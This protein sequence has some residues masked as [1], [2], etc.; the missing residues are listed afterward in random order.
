M[1][2]KSRWRFAEALPPHG[3]YA[4]NQIIKDKFYFLIALITPVDGLQMNPFIAMH[5]TARLPK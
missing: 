1:Q 5:I 3:S 4:I 2:H